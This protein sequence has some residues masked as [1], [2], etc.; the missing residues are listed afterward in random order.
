[1]TPADPPARGT[2]A[3]PAAADDDA[4]ADSGD[5]AARVVRAATLAGVTVA[6][7]ES[8]TGGAVADALVRVPG[9]SACLRGAV[10]AYATDV[11]RD[12]LGV[13]VALLERYGPVHP[14]VAAAMAAGVRHLL[15]ADYAVATTGVAGPGAQD[16]LPPGTVHVAVRGPGGTSLAS[17]GPDTPVPGGRAEV[18]AWARDTALALLLEALLRQGTAATTVR[19][20]D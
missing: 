8:L 12:V 20:A 2:P 14:D 3:G 6:V 9:A 1:M 11:K 4:G 5:L 19:Q 10:V 18:R 15:A 13:E 7:A 17:A 16:G